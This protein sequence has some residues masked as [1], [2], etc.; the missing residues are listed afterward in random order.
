MMLKKMNGTVR[1]LLG[2]TL[3]ITGNVTVLSRSVDSTHRLGFGSA[4]NYNTRTRQGSC[5]RQGNIFAC[6]ERVGMAR[7]RECQFYTEDNITVMYN[8]AENT[9]YKLRKQWRRKILYLLIG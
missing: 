3:K 2:C 1:N 5:R 8:K 7:K 6:N 9:L 4:G